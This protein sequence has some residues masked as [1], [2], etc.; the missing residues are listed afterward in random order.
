MIRVLEDS[1]AGLN[2]PVG[3]MA[4]RSPVR[5]SFQRCSGRTTHKPG[6]LR[7]AACGVDR[8]R[9]VRVRIEELVDAA[10]EGTQSVRPRRCDR[11]EARHLR[12][13]AG[14]HL[15]RRW[16]GGIIEVELAVPRADRFASPIRRDAPTDP[17]DSGCQPPEPVGAA[18]RISPTAITAKGSVLEAF[19]LPVWKPP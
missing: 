17:F 1:I 6:T 2:S 18:R 8:G 5:W 11:V 9:R 4:V 3:A 13:P 7:S 19:V 16:I 14:T 12:E 10:G 15:L